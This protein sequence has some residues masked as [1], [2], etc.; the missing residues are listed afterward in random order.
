MAAAVAPGSNPGG[1]VNCVADGGLGF[2]RKSAGARRSVVK[3]R[4]A[5]GSSCYAWSSKGSFSG[6]QIV[7]LLKQGTK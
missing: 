4:D 5:G 1:A 6:G 7:T 2:S 3:V